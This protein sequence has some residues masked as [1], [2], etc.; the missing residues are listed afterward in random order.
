MWGTGGSRWSCPTSG[1]PPFY[2]TQT[3]CPFPHSPRIRKW[4]PPLGEAA[5]PLAEEP[6]GEALRRLGVLAQKMLKLRWQQEP[7]RLGE[8]DDESETERQNYLSGKSRGLLPSGQETGRLSAGE[9]G[10]LLTFTT[11]GWSLSSLLGASSRSIT[12]SGN[13]WAQ[14]VQLAGMGSDSFCS[15]LFVHP[16]S[17]SATGR[18]VEKADTGRTQQVNLAASAA[19]VKRKDRVI[20]FKS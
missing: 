15:Q 3:R 7:A 18:D 16:G 20:I 10:P 2:L 17:K 6:F 9:P 5:P 11:A 14:P 8:A 13:S 19:K 1:L 12:L 4:E